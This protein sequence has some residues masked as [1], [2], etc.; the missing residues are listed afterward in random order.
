MA[1]ARNVSDALT[2]K[3]EFTVTAIVYGSDSLHCGVVSV[4]VML[5]GWRLLSGI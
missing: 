5:T 1:V 4:C 2:R 3:Y